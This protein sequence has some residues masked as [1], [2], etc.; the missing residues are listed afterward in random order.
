M[1]RAS[2]PAFLVTIDTEGDD[3]WS[4]PRT[5]TT[6]NTS[7]LPRFQ[8]MCETWGLRPTWLVNYEMA[9]D[10][11]FARFGR[12]VIRRDAGE[13]G[14]HLHAWNSPPLVP[15]TDDDLKHQ[16]YLIEYPQQVLEDKVAFMTS[17]L[18]ERFETPIV[19]HR[20]GRWGF[21]AHYACTLA[22]HGYL[23]DCSVCPHVSWR[24]TPGDPAG[25]GGPDFRRFPDRPY[26]LD[27]DRIDRPGA[28]NLLELPVSVLRS[29][30]HR[31]VPWAYVMPLV[32][33]LAW[34]WRPDRLWL[35]PDGTN[36]SEMFYIVDEALASGRPY[37]EMVLHSSELVPRS[38]GPNAADAERVEQLHS[39]VHAL[40]RYAASSFEGRTLAEFRREWL[41][42]QAAVEGSS[43]RA[44]ARAASGE[45]A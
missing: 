10:D 38:G 24:E 8:A 2:K 33:H 18:R 30:L 28:S 16:P 41:A 6:H 35:Y 15:L 27:L 43:G 40:F 13:I 9:M 7:A 11:A 31:V 45:R 25:D 1:T 37:V 19:S 44:P 5:I 42:A 36:R 39:D 21:D 17:L 29:P 26:L 3:L 20:A 32:R 4:R 14:M 23:V 22:R 12:D 34:A